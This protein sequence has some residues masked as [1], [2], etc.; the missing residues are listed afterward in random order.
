MKK[1]EQFMDESIEKLGFPG[2]D[3]IVYKDHKE[4]FRHTSG[5]SSLET[6]TPVKR[7]AM[8]HIYSATKM[9]TCVAVLQL[10]EQGKLLLE[11]HLAK[12]LPEFGQM[13]V[14]KGAH[15][16]YPAQKQIRIVDLLTMTAG[17]GYEM[18][19]PS[20]QNLRKETASDF[21]TREF[22]S[23]LAK[24]P[25]CFEPGENWNYSFCHDVL[26]VVIEEISG[27]SFGEY[28]KDNIFSPLGMQD[29]Y[30]S[31]PDEK[32]SRRAPRYRYDPRSEKIELFPFTGPRAVVGTRRESGG[33]GLIS[34]V[35][36][37][38]LFADALACGGTGKSGARI[39]SPAAIRLMST[40]RLSGAALNSYQ[41]MKGPGMGYGLGVAV[42]DD[43]ALAGS[44]VSRGSFTWGGL[45]GV[46]NLIDP[47]HKL[48]YFVAQHLMNCPKHKLMPYMWNILYSYL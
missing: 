29:T 32:Q 39:L 23:A 40:N 7:D 45:T 13:Q 9:I 4:I 16:F 15:D 31:V 28:L 18:N 44:L 27:M 30:F 47:E 22:V 2:I 26:A 6:K 20:V 21:T 10:L 48:S 5:Y 35:E 43:P 38:I 14:K 36:D 42:F 1:L 17:L 24:E 19:I 25:L 37:Y 11:D 34:T 41:M 3:C 12:Y 8:Y 46:Q 33:G